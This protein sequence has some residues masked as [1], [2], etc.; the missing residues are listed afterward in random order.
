[1][2]CG[3]L[4]VFA[5]GF[6]LGCALIAVRFGAHFVGVWEVALFGCFCYDFCSVCWLLRYIWWCC[7]WWV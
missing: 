5:F 7:L 2:R 4:L 1:M 3:L 6:S